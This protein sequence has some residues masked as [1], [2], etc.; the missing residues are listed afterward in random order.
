M[1]EL[2]QSSGDWENPPTPLLERATT[3]DDED[4]DVIDEVAKSDEVCAELLQ[5]ANASQ[6][7]EDVAS[8]ISDLLTGGIIN[9]EEHENLT[10]LHRTAFKR[11]PSIP[12]YE[13]VKKK[14]TRSK[15]RHCPFVKVQKGGKDLF[16]KT[17]VV[18]LLQ[19]SEECLWIVYF[20]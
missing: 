13:E 17:S 15:H 6:D 3:L 2:L 10:N 14:S 8:G 16:N 5:E 18:W 7:D 4:E 20:E 19:E 9:K 11:L 12:L 1:F